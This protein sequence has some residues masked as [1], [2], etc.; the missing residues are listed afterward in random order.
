MQSLPSGT[1]KVDAS[2]QL[3]YR[4][5]SALFSDIAAVKL[6]TEVSF[7]K[8]PLKLNYG[9]SLVLM[10]S[11]F[12]EHIGHWLRE[13]QFQ[14]QPNPTGIIYNPLSIAKHIELVLASG[15]ESGH[16]LMQS[17]GLYV[18]TDF[19]SQFA[20]PDKAEA[21][22]NIEKATNCL[23]NALLK[24]DV[25]F[26]TFGSAVMFRE[27]QGGEVV[28]NC[29]KLD[30]QLF[31][32]EMAEFEV[33][34]A[35]MQRAIEALRELNP[36]VHIYFTVS[37]VRHLRHGAVVNQQSKARLIL[38]CEKLCASL[39]GVAYIPVYEFVMDELRD[40]RFYDH[41]DLLHLNESGLGLLRAR[42]ESQL[43]DASIQPLL[44]KV[45]QYASMAKHRLLHPD[46]A[47]SHVFLRKRE[48]LCKEV[49]GAL[50]RSWV[51]V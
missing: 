48:A 7:P 30:A 25:L 3:V 13:L 42:L 39:A 36:G 47:Q 35:A 12:S 24:S 17:Q 45:K 33:M 38:L 21:W 5:H 19:H 51:E 27:K 50:E 29:H 32:Q 46:T 26:I 44:Q 34:Y 23:R 14:A 6:T 22:R 18:H 28:N 20:H 2:V 40:Y 4:S 43:F 41:A 49:E 16:A 15:W 9:Q 37:P 8:A 11:C 10:G 1:Y 31:Q